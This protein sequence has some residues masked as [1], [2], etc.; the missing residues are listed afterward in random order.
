MNE[1]R[2]SWPTHARVWDRHTEQMV[3]IQVMIDIDL[4]II[5]QQLAQKA[6]NNNSHQAQVANYGVKLT[7]IPKEWDK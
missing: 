6:Y 7:Y 2:Y 3:T 1:F 5:K 4:T